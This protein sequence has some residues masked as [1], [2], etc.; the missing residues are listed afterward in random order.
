MATAFLV[1]ATVRQTV[2]DASQRARLLMPESLTSIAARLAYHPLQP[3]I[4][5]GIARIARL[6]CFGTGVTGR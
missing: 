3:S 6:W 5:A 4:I 2:L 1:S